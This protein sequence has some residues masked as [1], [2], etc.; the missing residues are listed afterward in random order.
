MGISLLAYAYIILFLTGSMSPHRAIVR[1]PMKTHFVILI[2]GKQNEFVQRD[3]VQWSN[4]WIKMTIAQKWGMKL[5][6]INCINWRCCDFSFVQVDGNS[7]FE[8]HFHETFVICQKISTIF[9]FMVCP[10]IFNCYRG[11]HGGL[12]EI[13]WQIS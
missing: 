11:A 2:P 10:F 3:T 5:Q 4:F 1:A 7:I 6:M 12:S 8:C 9:F 13:E